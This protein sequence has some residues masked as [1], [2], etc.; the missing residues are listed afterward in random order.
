MKLLERKKIQISNVLQQHRK[1][2]IF[3]HFGCCIG[4]N[5]VYSRDNVYFLY[6]VGAFSSWELFFSPDTVSMHLL[7]QKWLM[8]VCV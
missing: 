2:P 7:E 5:V 3:F 1:L 6:L 4:Y 8:V